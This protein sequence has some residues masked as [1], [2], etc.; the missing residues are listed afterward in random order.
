MFELTPVSLVR[1]TRIRD[2]ISG[3]EAVIPTT[4]CC[5]LLDNLRTILHE[6]HLY[7]NGQPVWQGPITRLEYEYD[8]VRIFAEDVLWAAKRAAINPGYKYKSHTPE[9]VLDTVDMLLNQAYSRQGDPWNMLNVNGNLERT[10]L[11]AIRTPGEPKHRRTTY[12]WA[13]TVWNEVDK[14]GEDYGIDYTVVNRDVYYWDIHWEWKRLP[15]LDEDWIG[16][17]VKIVEYGNACYTRAIVSNGRG[18]AGIDQAGADVT[19]RRLYGFIDN[20]INNANDT[21]TANTPSPDQIANW[22]EQALRSLHNTYP[23]PVGVVV[24]ANTTLLPGAPW[25]IDD[26]IPGAWFKVTIKRL[27]RKVSE[28]NRLHEVRVEETPAGET[29]NFTAVTA[30]REHRVVPK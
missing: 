27:C 9:L 21:D 1:W 11:H 14:F 5:G 30:P 6:L 3:A 22:Q 2:D 26:L 8:Q 4:E 19:D 10:H 28:W 29:I 15:A 7:R 20:V 25:E 17:R 12:A 13:D 23:A 24:P 18:H 16:D